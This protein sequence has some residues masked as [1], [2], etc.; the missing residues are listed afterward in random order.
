[1][2]EGTS[3][4]GIVS[5]V[6]D[7]TIKLSFGGFSGIID[8][9]EVSDIITA[10]L[11]KKNF[12]TPNLRELYYIGQPLRAT[13]VSTEDKAI[14]LSTRASECNANLLAGSLKKG[15]LVVVEIK[16]VEDHGY[17]V[18]LAIEGAIGFIPKEQTVEYLA[19]RSRSE[20]VIGESLLAAITLVDA[21]SIQLSLN[22]LEISTATLYDATQITVDNS[23][24]LHKNQDDDTDLTSLTLKALKAGTLVPA[25]VTNTTPDGLQVLFLGIFEGVIEKRHMLPGVEH[26]VG[27]KFKARVRHVDY[28][29]KEVSLTLLPHLTNFRAF[30]FPE[31]LSRGSDVQVEVKNLQLG[32]SKGVN[33]TLLTNPPFPGFIRAKECDV[34][35][36]RDS[37]PV[38]LKKDAKIFNL[39]YLEGIAYVTINP[40]TIEK[41]TTQSYEPGV[42]V[43]CIVDS[44]DENGIRVRIG[45]RQAFIDLTQVSDVSFDRIPA[46][47]KENATL[48]AWVL[49]L[50]KG[51]LR[52]TLK[53]SLVTSHFPKIVNYVDLQVG[54][55]AH[56]V[57]VKILENDAGILVKFFNEVKGLLPRSKLGIPQDE[58]IETRIHIGQT[59][60]VQVESVKP[61]EE[62]LS[63]SRFTET[64]TIRIK[65]KENPAFH[66]YQL[67]QII[68]VKVVT[69]SLDGLQ[70]ETEDKIV[71]T[72]SVPHM[73]DFADYCERK[74][75]FYS[76][77]DRWIEEALVIEKDVQVFNLKLSLKMSMIS[78]V[79]A[80]IVIP[81]RTNQISANQ[82]IP[83]Y[84]GS[85][86][87]FGY[88]VNF[89]GTCSGL[90]PPGMVSDIN[91]EDSLR[92]GQ[93]VVACVKNIQSDS[94]KFSVYLKPSRVHYPLLIGISL[95]GYFWE[96]SQISQ[97]RSAP[98]FSQDVKRFQ[99]G[100]NVK[101]SVMASRDFGI[102]LK[103]SDSSFTGLVVSAQ[104]GQ[105]RGKEGD[106]VEATVLDVDIDKGIV[107]MTFDENSLNLLKR[108]KVMKVG[109]SISAIL[110]LIK[111]NYLVFVAQTQHQ[112]VFVPT[113]GDN[114]FDDPFKFYT[115][116]STY[117]LTITTVPNSQVE[118]PRYI[119]CF[120]YVG[121]K[122]Y[123]PGFHVG[124]QSKSVQVEI[125]KEVDPAVV[126]SI[127]NLPLGT[128]LDATILNLNP[129]HNYVEIFTKISGICVG[130]ILHMCDVADPKEG[131]RVNL[132]D[133]KIGSNV[134]VKILN[135]HKKQVGAHMFVGVR[136][137][138]DGYFEMTCRPSDM[139]LPEK[140]L[141]SRPALKPKSIV[142]AM[143]KE[144]HP[145]NGITFNLNSQ[146]K[147]HAEIIEI[148]YDLS[149]LANLESR[150]S[151]GDFVKVKI[152]EK[153]QHVTVRDVVQVE[154]PAKIPGRIV[155]A[156][157]EAGIVRVEIGHEQFG[158]VQLSEI[159][160]K[161]AATSL[162]EG[163][164][165]QCTVVSQ[166]GSDFK[167]KVEVVPGLK[168]AVPKR[169]IEAPKTPTK[170]VQ[171]E[172]Q[173]ENV[174][175]EQKGKKARKEAPAA[176][177]T[178]TDPTGPKTPTTPAKKSQVE[179]QVENQSEKGKKTK[180]VKP[181]P[182][183]EKPAP[184][185]TKAPT[186]PAKVP[187]APTT[188]KSGK[189]TPEPIQVEE[190]VQVEME[191]EKPVQK[192]KK[193]KEE[194]VPKTPTVQVEVKKEVEKS[195]PVKKAKTEE[196][197][198][199]ETP[200]KEIPK[201]SA[202]SVQVEK[203]VQ[204][205]DED[206]DEM[207]VDTK[208]T[209]TKNIGISPGFQFD[210]APVP[211]KMAQKKA[212]KA[213]EDLDEEFLESKKALIKKGKLESRAIREKE[214]SAKEA[215]LD[216]ITNNPQ[217]ASQFERA[218]LGQ[219]NNSQ[220][221]VQYMAL[222]ISQSEIDRARE[223]GKKALKTIKADVE[224][225]NDRLN[226]WVALLNI[227]NKFGRQDTLDKVF[228]DACCYCD[229][230]RI[231]FAYVDLLEK[232]GSIERCQ[233]AYVKA[234]KLFKGSAKLWL[235][236]G[237]FLMNQNQKAEFRGIIN[238]S[239][240]SIPAKKHVNVVTKYAQLEYQHGS[241]DQGR[242][243]FENLISSH[244]KRTDVWNVY[245]DMEEKEGD[246]SV[247]RKL[248]DRAI[249]LKLSTKKM[250][251]L[252]AR[253]LNFEKAKGDENSVQHVI[254]RAKEYVESA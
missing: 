176:P 33:V 48:T 209:K 172:S 126:D 90:C 15:M 167:L 59:I 251:T 14:S 194:S 34:P 80:N 158:L 63:L 202:K 122:R 190:D 205:E 221:W 36:D 210:D 181:T 62:K 249:S 149:V 117:Q 175:V 213:E 212:E 184:V 50:G 123:L 61:L 156:L 224:H 107:D 54:Q 136:A 127:L 103:F 74:L 234:L 111:V 243:L 193:R 9:A 29:G 200:K 225:E 187:T 75:E 253:F 43:T 67:G 161:S 231:Y 76:E 116:G 168:K 235:K 41:L 157:I 220:M 199:K 166:K 186:T 65:Q 182:E 252:F 125:K 105:F 86:M 19:S 77:K 4:L 81:S 37:F 232:A 58:P 150:F 165:V 129:E 151:V 248:Y 183:T 147:S 66:E 236:Y 173:V 201:K 93:S 237:T 250:K 195:T 44:V 239:L 17:P 11:N 247:V 79:K 72:I 69:S 25:T 70:V 246:V 12:D 22:P 196:T 97:K 244:P 21:G 144:V 35:V 106:Q 145:I 24:K 130:G 171:V 128:Q 52:L 102:V 226:I 92:V 242:I 206:E 222:H 204:V 139:S 83:G 1:M 39:D 115:P 208:P 219:P 82:I 26:Q 227:E 45:N 148:S 240:Q 203:P 132:S 120:E 137:L 218:L 27:D 169:P 133:F 109:D 146:T 3:V 42:K 13:V 64:S 197:P 60:R 170:K 95:E 20:L 119:A 88:F 89:L 185:P 228:Q 192:G 160:P 164:L 118:I 10:E 189:K 214:I 28:E 94:D 99:L 101:A 108:P 177:K 134:S 91:G 229:K 2:T 113:R 230:K 141:A 254:K 114:R 100:K 140:Q 211:A 96:Q 142:V 241:A 84:I 207:E 51:L 31:G 73:S 23:N 71:G 238:R 124:N 152:L 112:L 8:I 159:S 215:Q 154:K 68:R 217:T 85:I 198:K 6:S 153:I 53:K 78:A 163:D 110:M 47:I 191:V 40:T 30:Q 138:Q 56:G 223:V 135:A 16:S 7:L 46:K 98:E 162:K 57:V 104:K 178:P 233:N 155:M 143:V 49:S 188:P 174:E 180:E 179:T 245:L 38:G 55:Q 18:N 5:A 216:E 32:N 121:K 131:S 87:P